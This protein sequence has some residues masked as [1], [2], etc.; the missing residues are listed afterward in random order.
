MTGENRWQDAREALAEI[1][2]LAAKHNADGFDVYF[3]N[4]TKSGFDIKVRIG[5]LIAY[6]HF[7]EVSLCRVAQRS[8]DFSAQLT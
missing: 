7:I 3:L 6:M 8:C 4:D 1:A 5:T 2:D